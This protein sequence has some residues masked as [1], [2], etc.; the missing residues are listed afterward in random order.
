MSEVNRKCKE[1]GTWVED[2]H[3]G[4][5]FVDGTAMCMDCFRED[6]KYIGGKV[7]DAMKRG[8]LFDEEVE[9]SDEQWFDDP[10]WIEMN[11]G[12][13]FDVAWDSIIKM[14]WFIEGTGW[15]DP[16][17]VEGPI[18]SGGDA[19]DSPLYWTTDFNEALAYA[20]FG[21]AI[22]VS[23]LESDF[24]EQVPMRETIP[25]MRI[26]QDPG[27]NWRAKDGSVRDARELWDED[28]DLQN[29]IL[30]EDPESEG[31]MIDMQWGEPKHEKMAEDEMR[32]LLLSLIEGHDDMFAW[33]TTGA[34]KTA[35]ERKAH[36]KGA[37]ERLE[38]R[39]VMRN[40]SL[41][42]AHKPLSQVSETDMIDLVDDEEYLREWGR[43]E[44]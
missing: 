36:I 35:D 2:T 39:P 11:R 5:P 37:L 12:E 24:R 21:S 43:W 33:G 30:Q 20:L 14:P 38:T 16:K 17:T 29:Y 25:T 19:W 22:P 27:D 1:C 28:D 31:Y 40:I 9:A 3:E 44:D 23:G 8:G 10:E 32:N 42:D 6:Y 34:Y 15:T 7:M 26:A 4:V 41:D 18:Y 13:P